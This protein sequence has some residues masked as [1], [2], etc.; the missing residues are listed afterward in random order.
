MRKI[1]RFTGSRRKVKAITMENAMEEKR[2]SLSHGDADDASKNTLK[3]K[4]TV[5]K[6]PQ[7]KKGELS[8]KN[9]S[10]GTE[11]SVDAES[12]E[13]HRRK[14]VEVNFPGGLITQ[15]QDKSKHH[16]AEKVDMCI[17]I[18]RHQKDSS[19]DLLESDDPHFYKVVN[20][21]Y[22][23]E[24][25]DGDGNNETILMRN[26]K[27]E[28]GKVTSLRVIPN[29]LIFD[30]IHDVHIQLGHSKNI[31]KTYNEMKD[32][33][34]C[35]SEKDVANF[36][37]TCPS[38]FCSG[39]PCKIPK[40]FGKN[41][42]ILSSF[43]RDRSEMGPIEFNVVNGMS[44]NKILKPIAH[45][46]REKDLRTL[47]HVGLMARD[48]LIAE[49]E[50]LFQSPNDK[51][52]LWQ[53]LQQSMQDYF[54]R[55]CKAPE[56]GVRFSNAAEGTSV[57]LDDVCV[58]ESAGESPNAVD[59]SKKRCE[60]DVEDSKPEKK[61]KN[62]DK[63][64]KQSSE[65]RKRSSDYANVRPSA[66]SAF[67]RYDASRKCKF[68]KVCLECQ[69]CKNSG[70]NSI[71]FLIYYETEYY[72]EMMMTNRWFTSNIISAFV[73]LKMHKHHR[74]DILY[75]L[76]SFPTSEPED[77]FELPP[78]VTDI[79]AILGDGAHFVF[80]QINI[81]NRFILVKDGR[82]K[83]GEEKKWEAHINFLLKRWGLVKEL[84]SQVIWSPTIVTTF[85]RNTPTTSEG[86]FEV[87]P[88]KAVAQTNDTECG[89]IAC[90]HAWDLIDPYSKPA[91]VKSFREEVLRELMSMWNDFDNCLSARVPEIVVV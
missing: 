84:C 28:N 17:R 86:V 1:Q 41:N 11:M 68:L 40:Q 79:I 67:Y 16:T 20:N 29:D 49:V 23:D 55:D 3:L 72:K 12:K 78:R 27:D 36:I 82:V 69:T 81:R 85:L 35:V 64:T 75:A 19:V 54:D 24:S 39:V 83:E 13:Q 87:I 10:P 73:T 25:A 71:E 7:K 77:I 74:Q 58:G 62:D 50:E 45:D 91:D 8:K 42:P 63:D 15:Y 9:M 6:K 80:V 21:Y 37:Q 48:V 44:K 57:V 22:L 59:G 30:C 89:P 53:Y 5:K 65:T 14:F 32:K 26:V 43:L 66:A 90:Y 4:K 76:V 88:F 18:L 61:M 60:R 56:R 52:A 38:A 47:E 33:H 34:Y 2:T 51:M 31:R 70:T 46:G